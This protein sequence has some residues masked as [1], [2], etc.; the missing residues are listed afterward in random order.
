[1]LIVLISNSRDFISLGPHMSYNRVVQV[2][3][4]GGEKLCS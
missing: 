1:M 2:T 3:A 4:L